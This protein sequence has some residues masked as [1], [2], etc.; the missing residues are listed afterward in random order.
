MQNPPSHEIELFPPDIF[1][2]MLDH[3]VNKS[4]RYGD[5]LTLVDLLVEADPSTPE[6]QHGAEMFTIG[7]LN[8]QLRNTDIPCKRGNEFL[9]LMPSTSAPGARTACERIKKQMTTGHQNEN[10]STFTLSTYI[11]MAALPIDHAVSSD[12][13]SR[14]ASQALHYVRI[15]HRTD[16]VEFSETQ[17]L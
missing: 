17:K 15:N 10:D 1:K 8:I 6:A 16:V 2:M 11:G 4:R 14:N 12:E 13:L 3:E 5:S 7:V 9:I